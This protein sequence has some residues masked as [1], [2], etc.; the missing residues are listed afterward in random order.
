MVARLLVW[1]QG[2]NT[3]ILTENGPVDRN[4]QPF[5]IADAE[6]IRVAHPIEMSAED[7]KAWQQYICSNGVVQPFEQ[8][9]EPARNPKTVSKDRYDGCQV[10]V[11][12]FMNKIKHGIH[13]ED[14]DFHN[15]IGFWLD[16]CTLNQDRTSPC[17]HEIGANETFTLGTFSFKKY[18]RKVNHLV[19]LLDKWTV[20]ER[21]L[22]DD[23]SVQDLL[24]GFTMAQIIG[25]IQEATENQCNN[26]LAMLLDYK[27]RNFTDFDPMEEF[28]LDL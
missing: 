14:E 21:I 16:D 1:A 5:T 3:F 10:S 22:K 26:V 18:T 27:D 19:S 12:K 11:F 23:V 28:S 8:M 20:S 6:Q 24:D 13:F 9:W 25:F 7:V 2:K 15:Y 17:R 4:G